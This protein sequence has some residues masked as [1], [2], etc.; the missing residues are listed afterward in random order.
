VEGGFEIEYNLIMSAK[1][2]EK[3]ERG[4]G[5]IY[6]QGAAPRKRRFSMRGGG[7][8]VGVDVTSAVPL[9]DRCVLVDVAPPKGFVL[10]DNARV[11]HDGL[12]LHPLTRASAIG[13]WRRRRGGQ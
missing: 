11:A 13:R 3:G 9:D 1:N 5:V 2:K 12:V 4:G 10:D 6:Q 7:L 8:V